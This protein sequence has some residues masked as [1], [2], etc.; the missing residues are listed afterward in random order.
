MSLSRC[1]AHTEL[2]AIIRMAGLL[3]SEADERLLLLVDAV[4]CIIRNAAAVVPCFTEL[5]LQSFK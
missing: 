3:K 5:L 2:A 1:F 4:L